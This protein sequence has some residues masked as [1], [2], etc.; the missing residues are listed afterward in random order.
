MRPVFA[1]VLDP[2]LVS[3]KYFFHLLK[4][5]EVVENNQAHRSM[6]SCCFQQSDCGSALA[7]CLFA[8]MLVVGRREWFLLVL[9]FSWK[10]LTPT[11]LKLCPLEAPRHEARIWSGFGVFNWGRQQDACDWSALC[12]GLA[13][14]L[15]TEGALRSARTSTFSSF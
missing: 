8:A 6:V 5:Q 11:Q 13:E 1:V 9:V 3:R 15:L 2:K 4:E 10:F 7:A 12:A 14:A